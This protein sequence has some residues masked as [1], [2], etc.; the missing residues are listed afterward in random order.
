MD[1]QNLIWAL[2][3]AQLLLLISTGYLIIR[4]FLIG[5]S[6]KQELPFVPSAGKAVN[7]MVELAELKDGDSICDL[8][9]GTGEVMLALAKRYPRSII[10][11]FEI[12]RWLRIN[13]YL[14]K[15]FV[16]P[17]A[18]NVKMFNRDLFTLDL[19]KYQTVVIF[20][21]P[22]YIARLMGKFEQLPIGTKII[23]NIFQVPV[24]KEFFTEQ[25]FEYSPGTFVYFYKKIR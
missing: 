14:K 1:T 9:A 4:I 10:E 23:S 2:L 24:N 15:L 22:S 16:I 5:R 3:A 17:F 25:A 18:K 6:M 20:G 7:L 19:N 11:G 12:D 13:Y 8:G 21:V